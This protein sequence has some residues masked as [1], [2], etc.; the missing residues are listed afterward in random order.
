MNTNNITVQKFNLGTTYRIETSV[1]V[2]PF[3]RDGHYVTK[4]VRVQKNSGTKYFWCAI[5]R[6][7][8]TATV[9]EFDKAHSEAQPV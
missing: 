6:K 8:F 1:T 7:Y 4:I 2:K 3:K 5:G 9:A